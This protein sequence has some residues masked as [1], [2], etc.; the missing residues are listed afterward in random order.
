MAAENRVR[1]LLDHVGQSKLSSTVP[2][3]VSNS[4]ATESDTQGNGCATFLVVSHWVVGV[5]CCFFLPDFDRAW[6]FARAKYAQRQLYDTAIEIQIS[7]FL[8]PVAAIP[9]PVIPRVMR[10][11]CTRPPVPAI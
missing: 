3:R 10:S 6:A 11:F 5:Y 9:N 7:Q 8:Y 4:D 1:K 2:L